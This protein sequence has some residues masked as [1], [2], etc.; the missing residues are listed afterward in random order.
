MKKFLC[1]ISSA[2]VVSA[3]HADNPSHLVID[4]TTKSI[5]SSLGENN[6]RPIASITKLM[7]AL[8]IVESNLDMNELVSY[9]GG[10]FRNKKVKRS[11]LLE[12]LLI[13]SDNAAAEALAV[14]FIGGRQAFINT[15]NNRAKTLGM[16]NTFFEDPSG[17]GK[18]NIS[19]AIDLS[20]L[21]DKSYEYSRISETSSSKF[22]K[23][24]NVNKRKVTYVTVENTNSRLL[25]VFD[26]IVLSK[27]GFTSPAGRC[28]GI[29]VEKNKTKYAIIILGEKN[30]NDRFN[31]AQSLI[32]MVSE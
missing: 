29:V 32:S 30:S 2:L 28:L 6:V 20:I 5:I 10:I 21:I 22:F 9:Q 13:K 18:N 3:A 14:S 12:S 4:L 16:N 31:R 11:E 19:T 1:L 25:N 8:V 7:T 15:M 17:L 26:N 23:V 24:E 27:T